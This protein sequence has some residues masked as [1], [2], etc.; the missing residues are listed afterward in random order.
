MTKFIYQFAQFLRRFGVN[1]HEELNEQVKAMQE[2]I[3]KLNGIQF[4]IEVFGDGSWTAESTN[5]EG[6]VTGGTNKDSMNDAMKDALFTYFEIP[7][8]FCN[9]K[10]I[11][12]SNEPVTLEQR[13]YA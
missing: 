5:I 12:Y 4:K 10:L 8:Q 3:Q 13:V 7:P 2:T 1:F 9:D 11:K 6:I